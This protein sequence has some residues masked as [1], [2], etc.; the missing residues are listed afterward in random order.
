MAD[1]DLD[2]MAALLGDPEVMRYYPRPKSR[3]EALGWIL[4]NRRNYA[5]HGYGLWIVETHD[6]EFVGDCG[7][8][9]QP[10]NGKQV[11]EVGYHTVCALQGRGY[12]SEAARTCVDLAMGPIGESRVIAIINP[13]NSP[14]RRVA[15]KVGMRVEQ[16]TEVRGLPVVIYGRPG[17]DL[18]T[19]VVR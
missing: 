9:W 15:E 14:S 5:E 18:P 1:S 11:L 7:L 6:G 10:V 16:V 8:T 17:E 13:D 3:D 2:R 19:K 12:A 4:W